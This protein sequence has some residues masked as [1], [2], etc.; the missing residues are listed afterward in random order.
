MMRVS[1]ILPCSRASVVATLQLQSC[2]MESKRPAWLHAQ[3]GQEGQGPGGPERLSSVLR[4][5]AV[6]ILAPGRI[7]D[8]FSIK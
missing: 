8:L 2:H 5:R 6:R 4:T 7:C 3:E 1:L